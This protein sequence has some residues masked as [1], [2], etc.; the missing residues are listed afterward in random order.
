MP[1]AFFRLEKIKNILAAMSQLQLNN[2]M[3]QHVHKNLTDTL[4]LKIIA[5]SF[6]NTNNTGEDFLGSCKCSS[7]FYPR[8]YIRILLSFVLFLFIVIFLYV[9]VKIVV[10]C[11]SMV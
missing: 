2:L 1:K 4:D 7:E 6:A 11:Q 3:V 9:S 8:L 5:R 10:V